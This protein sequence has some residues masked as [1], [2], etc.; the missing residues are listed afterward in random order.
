MVKS[1]KYEKGVKQ[2]TAL[3]TKKVGNQEFSQYYYKP[4]QIGEF[5]D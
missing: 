5:T 3:R 2:P 1:H 4:I